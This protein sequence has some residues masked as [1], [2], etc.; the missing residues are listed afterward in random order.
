MRV[1]VSD[2]FSARMRECV[3]VIEVVRERIRLKECKEGGSQQN[4]S[5]KKP[6][7]ATPVGLGQVICK[8]RVL[9][10]MQGL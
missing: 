1:Y 7:R 9:L 4:L 5:E 3:H 10:S 8:G 2:M 6:N